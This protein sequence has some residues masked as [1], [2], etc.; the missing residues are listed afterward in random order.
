ML[1]VLYDNVLRF[2]P[3]DP[4]WPERDRCILSKGHGCITLYVM[5]ADKGFF[6]R[7]ELWKF[8]H[9]DAILGG[10][11]DA[12]KIPGV[13]STTGSLGHGLS[14]GIGFALNARYDKRDSRV[15]VVLGDGECN[16]GSVWEAAMSAGKYGLTNLTVLID[17]N[18]YQSY[19]QTA[20]VQ[21]LEPFKEKWKSFGFGTVDINGHDVDALK[22]TLSS[23]PVK[24]E[25]PSALIC[26]TVKGKGIHFAENNL[27]WHH[28]NKIQDEVAQEMLACLEEE[29]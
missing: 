4:S 13:E 3:D 20:L 5:L 9:H 12:I 18:K 24:K 10:H 26:H 16:E 19:D 21:E 23:L 7:E 22:K 27:E 29:N 2:K 25:K 15:F 28:K 1:R 17:Y 14:V 11:P 8:C 6:P